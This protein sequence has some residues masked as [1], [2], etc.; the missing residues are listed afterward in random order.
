MA[1]GSRCCESAKIILNREGIC[2]EDCPF[3]KCIYESKHKTE[4]DTRNANII[5]LFAKG[6]H[7]SKISKKYRLSIRTIYR[8]IGTAKEA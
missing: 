8:I 2:S 7:V 4:L 1:V 5:R 6:T 3:E